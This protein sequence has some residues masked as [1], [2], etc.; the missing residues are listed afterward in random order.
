MSRHRKGF[1]ELGKALRE[2]AATECK[3]PEQVPAK[4]YYCPAP[5]HGWTA[6]PCACLES[7]KS[8][9][10]ADKSLEHEV[11]CRECARVKHTPDVCSIHFPVTEVPAPEEVW[12]L[13]AENGDAYDGTFSSATNAEAYARMHMPGPGATAVRYVRAREGG[14]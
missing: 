3:P 10:T 4:P 8:P 9:G 6:T 11:P 7:I 14:R 12:I 1:A 5:R 13:V 2:R